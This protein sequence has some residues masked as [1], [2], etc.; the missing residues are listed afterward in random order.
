MRKI[1]LFAAMTIVMAHGLIAHTHVSIDNS[2]HHT[3]L[4]REAKTLLDYFELGFHHEAYDGTMEI[5]QAPDDTS[6]EIQPL[7]LAFVLRVVLDL[8]FEESAHSLPVE[9]E[10]SGTSSFLFA[11]ALSRRGPPSQLV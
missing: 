3:A 9:G 2:D 4:H 7:Q 10:N 8:P 1:L 11:S 6:P 5:Y